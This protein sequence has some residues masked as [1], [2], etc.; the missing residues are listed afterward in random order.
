MIQNTKKWLK[1][2]VSQ[3]KGTTKHQIKQSL[4][5]RIFGGGLYY[6]FHTYKQKTIRKAQGRIKI[7]T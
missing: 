4:F 2:L 7:L 1:F 5:I 3:Y 6:L